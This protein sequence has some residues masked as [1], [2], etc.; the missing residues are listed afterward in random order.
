MAR[1]HSGPFTLAPLSGK[2]LRPA[3]MQAMAPVSLT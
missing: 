1:F 2:P 3:G